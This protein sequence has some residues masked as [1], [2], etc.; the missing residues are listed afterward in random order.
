MLQS[1]SDV[2]PVEGVRN[3][4][5]LHS[6]QTEKAEAASAV[7]FLKNPIGQSSQELVSL[8]SCWPLGQE[9]VRHVRE[10]LK[11]VEKYQKC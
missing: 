5:T 11:G 9:S 8:L 4:F 6:T 3:P 10:S 7:L 2:A 1:L